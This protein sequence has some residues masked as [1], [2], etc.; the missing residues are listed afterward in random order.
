M[1]AQRPAHLP[2]AIDGVAEALPFPDRC[3]DAA[4]STFSIHQWT[5]VERGLREM[6]RVARG[7]VLILSCDPAAVRDF[8]LADYVP[9]VLEAE[10]RR[11][12]SLA[13]I[14]T[15]LGG[16]VEVHV[17]EIPVDCSDGFNEAYYGRPE[18]FL[19]P[20]ARLACSAWSFV[21]EPVVDSGVAR[22]ASDLASGVWDGKH[23]HL[24]SQPG[25][26][27]SLR[28]VVAW[29]TSTDWQRTASSTAPGRRP[30]GPAD[31]AVY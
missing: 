20:R 1:R 8:W 12:P 13:R 29:P 7:P 27:G 31:D 14:A 30:R 18:M 5:D 11:Y 2:P 24:R 4:L 15:V 22:L 23:G 3:F 10:A 28:L 21:P 17:V 19:D 25:L 9:D 6:R 26:A 16:R